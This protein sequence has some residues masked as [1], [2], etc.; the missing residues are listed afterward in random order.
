MKYKII[1]GCIIQLARKNIKENKT[2]SQNITPK[3]IF[4]FM[5]PSK[6]KPGY[7]TTAIIDID[8]PKRVCF[9]YL[10]RRIF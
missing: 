6:K 3:S 5:F 8:P 4:S 2:L 7:V 1:Y 10:S 9:T